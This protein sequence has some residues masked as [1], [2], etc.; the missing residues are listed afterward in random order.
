MIEEVDRSLERW[1]RAAVP[2]PSGTADVVF[3]QPERDWD[4]RRSTP[5]V[6]LF[7]Y[8][9]TPSE[10]RA[11]TGSRVV[12]RDGGG[13]GRERVTP[14][15]QARY[16]ISVWGGGS[17]VEHELLGRIV[18]LLA[19]SRAIP[20]EH[21]G[22]GLRAAK[23]KPTVSLVPDP[24]TTLPQL[25][26][27]LTIPPRAGVQLLVETPVGIPVVTP[28]ADPPRFLQLDTGD[29]RRPAAY[30]QRRRVFGRVDPAAAGGRVVGRRG[31]AVIEDTGRYN[32]EAD[33]DDELT[34]LPPE[35]EAAH[36]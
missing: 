28:A 3:E 31:S 32:V 20:H 21:L 14:V 1:L 34:V 19:R 4:A 30:S 10:K 7:L 18:N 23:P 25:W 8:S 17:G 11:A 33:P 6:D 15:M 27:A 2:L 22:D 16:L 9:V 35:G 5:L 13:L 12:P 36:G 29:R 24:S 26:Q